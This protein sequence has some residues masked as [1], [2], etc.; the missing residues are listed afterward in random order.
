MYKV[1][2]RVLAGE[3]AWLEEGIVGI[4]EEAPKGKG[5]AGDARTAR[6]RETEG[7]GVG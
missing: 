2:Q 4:M 3:H 6:L 5:S 1:S 7:V